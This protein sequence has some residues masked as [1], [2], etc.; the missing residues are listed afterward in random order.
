MTVVCRARLAHFVWL[1]SGSRHGVRQLPERPE[2]ALFAAQKPEGGFGWW[3]DTEVN[4]VHDPKRVNLRT[5]QT[6]GWR[7]WRR[8]ET[9]GVILCFSL[10]DPWL[11]ELKDIFNEG[12]AAFFCLARLLLDS[13]AARFHLCWWRCACLSPSVCLFNKRIQEECQTFIC[14]NAWAPKALDSAAN[15]FCRT[16]RE[17][18]SPTWRGGGGGVLHKAAG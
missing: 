11:E 12:F 2:V 1:R 14:P 6:F 7:F 4:L 15:A 18:S 9:T 8:V 5:R 3:D 13:S 16:V 10:Q 17:F